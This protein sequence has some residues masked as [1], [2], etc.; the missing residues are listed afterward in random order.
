MATKDFVQGAR[1]APR[2]YIA[3][4]IAELDV[5]SRGFIEKVEQQPHRIDITVQWD[6]LGELKVHTPSHL[7]IAKDKPAPAEPADPT[8]AASEPEPEST[9][10]PEAE[11]EREESAHP[12]V[13]GGAGIVVALEDEVLFTQ[14]DDPEARKADTAAHG[15]RTARQRLMDHLSR[16][17]EETGHPNVTSYATARGASEHDLRAWHLAYHKHIATLSD[18]LT[19]P[20]PIP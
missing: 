13:S 6:G 9:P 5:N 4:R 17:S 11:P 16:P 2:R 20:H 14:R 19:G 18:T 10:E 3:E 8:E 12:I 1:V 15:G 7:I